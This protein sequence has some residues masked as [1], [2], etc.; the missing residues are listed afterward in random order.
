[1][2]VTSVQ[3]RSVLGVTER[4]LK[5]GKVTAVSGRNA[6]GKSSIL[7]AIQN[8]LG[9]GNLAKLA[10][11]GSES[12]PEVVL[13]LDDGAY[14]VEK[15]SDGTRVRAR[16]GTSAAYEDVRRP[17]S[18]LDSLF[19]PLLSN[20]VRFLQAK[21]EDRA[22]L[23]LE[24]LP[25]EMDR[26]A[27]ASAIGADG[28]AAAG[29]KLRDPGHPL[30]VLG[31]IREAIFVER[32]GVNVSAKDKAASAYE[33]QKAL[34]AE[35]PGDDPAG[36]IA[37]AERLRDELADR[38]SRETAAAESAYSRTRA[39]AQ[40]SRDKQKAEIEEGFRAQAAK[41]R[42]KLAKDIAQLER[43]AE[44]RIQGLRERGEATL[45][46]VERALAAE[47]EQA[48]GYRR[49]ALDAIAATR[50]ELDVA[51]ARVTELRAGTDERARLHETKRL[52]DKFE[53]EAADLTARS[54]R[55]TKALH[56][57][58]AFKRALLKDLPIEG[59]EVEGREIKVNGVPFDQVNTALRIR[60]AVQVATLR[61]TGRALPVVFVDG[62]EA[63]DHEQFDVLVKELEASGVQAFLSRVEDSELAVEALA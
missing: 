7:A 16:V 40:A 21:P 5:C 39:E 48:A 59:L 1:M 44:A 46:A 62:A 12:E 8:A 2:R 36:E 61:A 28:I 53:G 14:R 29:S 43:E 47:Q 57:L 19:D 50:K 17:Q 31:A 35:M 51:K 13:V 34:P 4:S 38:V 20:P 49:E 60:I 26:A 3:I 11:V 63:L 45:E 54:E 58:D 27:L 33:L 32:T 15:A 9:G 30:R 23:L 10:S 37:E 56:S 22:D 6:S 42:A 25:L 52:A 55:L 24:A 18:W 41:I